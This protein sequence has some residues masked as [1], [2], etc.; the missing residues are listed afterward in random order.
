[1]KTEVWQY[2]KFWKFF[3]IYIPLF[4]FSMFLFI[5]V[6]IIPWIN[7]EYLITNSLSAK[8]ILSGIAIFFMVMGINKFVKQIK[9]YNKLKKKT[10]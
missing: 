10:K 2:D 4:I 6:A 9:I 5:W 1:M 3:I 7:S 8:L